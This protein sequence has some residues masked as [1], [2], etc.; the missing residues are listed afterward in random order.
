[1]RESAFAIGKDNGWLAHDGELPGFNAQL[2]H[3]PKGDIT[4]VV[5]ANSDVSVSGSTATPAPVI[6]SALAGVVTPSN[7]P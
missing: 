1:V 3:F 2:A 4:I 7:I 6:F 5:L